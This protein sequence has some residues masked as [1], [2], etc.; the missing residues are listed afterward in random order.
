MYVSKRS[1]KIKLSPEISNQIHTCCICIMFQ[2]Q[3]I[4]VK[5]INFAN[6]IPISFSRSH[7]DLLLLVRVLNNCSSPTVSMIWVQLLFYS[8]M[9]QVAEISESHDPFRK[10]NV[11]M[12]NNWFASSF[13]FQIVSEVKYLNMY[14]IWIQCKH[15]D[16]SINLCHTENRFISNAWDDVRHLT[17]LKL[18]KFYLPNVWWV[19]VLNYAQLI[20]NSQQSTR[21]P[22]HSA[23]R[24]H[25]INHFPIDN[26]NTAQ[27]LLSH[28][29]YKCYNDNKCNK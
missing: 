3:P 20:S 21:H 13:K 23:Y 6:S 18:F 1:L 9:P 2:M 16:F 5:F 15:S 29:N 8:I 19:N 4:E 24:V 28:T 14:P 11:N 22:G 7:L 10:F 26:V 12:F 17:F 25:S 27:Y